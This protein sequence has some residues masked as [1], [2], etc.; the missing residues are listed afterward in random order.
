MIIRLLFLLL[1]SAVLF[2]CTNGKKTEKET[3][4]GRF[5]SIEETRAYFQWHEDAPRLISA[6]RGGPYPGYPENSIAAFD[7]VL[8]YADA[9]IECDVAVTKDGKLIMMHDDKLDRTTTGSGLVKNKTWE[10]I[11]GLKLKDR[12]NQVTPFHIPTLEEVL[13]WS[14]GKAFLTLDIKRGVSLKQVHQ[15]IN[16]TGTAPNVAIITYS[17]VK[18]KEVFKMNPELMISIT[19]RNMEDIDRIRES[20]IN[21]ENLIAFTGISEPSP[22]VYEELH[23]MGI[24]TILGALGNLDRRALARGDQYYLQLYGNGADIMA[25]DRP[26]EVAR[27]LEVANTQ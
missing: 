26:I 8:Q 9:I 3:D 1:T 12:D 6:H 18:A 13:E 22:E 11:K 17:L 25:T 10:E 21:P 2:S 16:Q 19:A 20:G 14:K 23:Q 7:H 27:Q 5:A 4:G 24:Y 15:L